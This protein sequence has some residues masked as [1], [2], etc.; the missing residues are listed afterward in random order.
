EVL[1]H[2]A[3]PLVGLRE[4]AEERSLQLILDGGES[5]DLALGDVQLVLQRR[6]EVAAEIA[7]SQ[8]RAAE[9]LDLA[10]REPES[11]SETDVLHRHHGFLAVFAPASL[12]LRRAAQ[13]ADALVE[14]NRLHPDAGFLG[15]HSDRP[16]PH[17]PL[18]SPDPPHGSMLDSVPRY[19][20]K[21]VFTDNVDPA[22]AA[23]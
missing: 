1:H 12:G 2:R 14:A 7:A 9:L 18:S 19:R 10:E 23:V 11:L 17:G 15:E 13:Q 3:L 6:A 20:V 21:R 4:A 16:S 5:F 22:A 8:Q